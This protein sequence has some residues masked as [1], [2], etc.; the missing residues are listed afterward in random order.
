MPLDFDI[1]EIEKTQ[2]GKGLR[3]KL[4][5]ALKE[6]Q[7]LQSVAAAAEAEKVIGTHG[8]DLITAEDLKGVGLGEIEAKAA[9]LQEQKQTE[10]LETVKS[11]FAA[12]GYEGE[13]LDQAVEDFIGDQS[14]PAS[15]GSKFRNVHES[16]AADGKPAPAVDVS[17]LHGVEAIAH[18]LGQAEKKRK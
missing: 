17:K 13:D 1:D 12:K 14:Q 15:D 8:Y 18:A 5:E 7:K 16:A 3:R 11:I 4:E 9:E 2:G 10:R 6:N